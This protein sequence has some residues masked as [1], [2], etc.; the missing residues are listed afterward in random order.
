M[1]SMF[2]RRPHFDEH[3]KKIRI[4]VYDILLAGFLQQLYLFQI[5]LVSEGEIETQFKK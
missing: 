1:E 4:F 5:P 3:I 2:P